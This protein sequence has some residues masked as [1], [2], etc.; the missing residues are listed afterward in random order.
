MRDPHR[1]RTMGLWDL[2]L[3]ALSL[4]WLWV[5]AG[6]SAGLGFALI[7]FGALGV[8]VGGLLALFRHQDVRAKQALARG[9]S[10]PDWHYARLAG[11]RR[12]D[13]QQFVIPK[14]PLR[15]T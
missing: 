10:E 15:Y 14:L 2:G 13:W 5:G 4:A 7:F 1:W 11:W 12:E 3:G 8:V 6:H 9:E